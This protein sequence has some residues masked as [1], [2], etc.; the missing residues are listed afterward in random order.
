MKVQ[1]VLSVEVDVK[2]WN[3]EYGQR[4]T[5]AQIRESI[6]ASISQAAANEFDHLRRTI[7][8]EQQPDGFTS[9]TTEPVVTVTVK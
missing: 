3:E 1:I 9:Y 8:G 5:P 4:E 7:W 6:K 2:G